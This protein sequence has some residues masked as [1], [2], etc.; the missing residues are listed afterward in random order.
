M[1]HHE[2]PVGRSAAGRIVRV[3]CLTIFGVLTT[4]L[5]ACLIPPVLFRLA[6]GRAPLSAEKYQ[7]AWNTKGLTA[8]QLRELLGEPHDRY[9]EDNGG[10]TWYYWGDSYGVGYVGIRIGPDGRVESTWG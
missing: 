4:L 5:V 8:N 10:E 6:H 1:S 7:R 2:K 3:F 9:D